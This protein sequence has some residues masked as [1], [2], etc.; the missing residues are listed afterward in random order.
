MFWE[1]ILFSF[2]FILHFVNNHNWFG[3][4]VT[5]FNRFCYTCH[6]KYC[7]WDHLCVYSHLT[8]QIYQ[9]GSYQNKIMKYLQ[10]SGSFKYTIYYGK[11]VF[12]PQ[13]LTSIWN[14]IPHFKI[15]N[16]APHGQLFLLSHIKEFNQVIKMPFLFLWCSF[17]F[18]LY[19]FTYIISHLVYSTLYHQ[20]H[21][22]I[23]I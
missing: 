11:F 15:F 1:G 19:L 5:I 2:N 9:I 8:Q 7:W 4:F 12:A 10:I 22:A 6:H 23:Y 16:F 18:C 20:H 17:L 14:C 13:V 21:L 3:N